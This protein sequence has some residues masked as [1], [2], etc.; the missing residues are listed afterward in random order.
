LRINFQR[1]PGEREA[2]IFRRIVVWLD[3]LVK[4][5]GA[6]AHGLEW[7]ERLGRPLVPISPAQ[8][9]RGMSGLPQLLGP[10]D[11]LV[12]GAVLPAA[13]KKQLLRHAARCAAAGVLVCPGAWER[14]S[15]VLVLHE[16]PRPPEG[17]LTAAAEVCRYLGA[18]PVLLTVARSER[19]AHRHQQAAREVLAGSGLGAEWDVV[20]GAEIRAAATR[21]ARW[22]RCQAV[23]LERPPAPP[24]WRRWQGGTLAKFTGPA[25]MVSLLALSA[26]AE[27]SSAEI[28]LAQG[29]LACGSL[30]QPLKILTPS[31][32]WPS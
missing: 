18:R 4:S 13:E 32:S 5:D 15:R 27:K 12:L 2:A 1:R 19:V 31:P 9:E 7:A 22:R 30:K 14:W 28:P 21:V 11:L 6:L 20:I 17:F 24:W 10:G 26:A 29:T 3:H 25:D 23:L 8:L 16:A